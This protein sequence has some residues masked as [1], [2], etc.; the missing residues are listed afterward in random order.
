LLNLKPDLSYREQFTNNLKNQNLKDIMIADYKFFLSEMMLFKV[1]RTSMANSL[2]IRSPFLDYRLIE[3]VLGSNLTF[4]NTNN[5]KQIMK[6]YLSEDFNNEFLNRKKQGFVFDV[7]NWVY[8]NIDYIASELKDSTIIKE[9]N[10][11]ILRDLSLFKTR[12]NGIRI[13]KLFVLE[14]FMKRL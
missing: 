4:I 7:E 3:Y 10:K 13:W 2:E 11:N 12:M 14:N 6:E 8:E 1:D 5:S 9:Y